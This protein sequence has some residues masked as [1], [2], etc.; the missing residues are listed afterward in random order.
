MAD[1]IIKESDEVQDTD[2]VFDCPHCGKSLCID[3]RGAGLNITCTDCG[4]ETAVPIPNGME[5]DDLDS[6]PQDQEVRIINLRNSLSESDTRANG[7]AA[8][9]EVLKTRCTELKASH[10]AVGQNADE[11]R[12]R[13][14]QIEKAQADI[15]RAVDGLSVLLGLGSEDAEASD[16]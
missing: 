7:L 8:E 10:D 3:Y 13:I 16:Q 5:L 11:V 14:S 15:Y 12:E 1:D 4:N 2:I 9:V 6:T